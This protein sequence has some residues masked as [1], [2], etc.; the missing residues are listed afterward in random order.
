MPIR[1]QEQFLAP[2][3]ADVHFLSNRGANG[4]D[5][6]ISSGIGAAHASGRPTTIV[7]GELGFLHDIGA[8]AALRDVTT[9]VRI[10]VIDNGG[11]GIFHFL[12]QQTALDPAEFEALFG[13]PRAVSVE[14]AAALFDLPYRRLESLADLP[15][16]LAAGTG[17]IEVRTDRG[18]QR[19]RPPP[20]HRARPR[21]PQQLIGPAPR[22]APG[23]QTGACT[24][25]S[26]R[27][28]SFAG[29][30]TKVGQVPSAFDCITSPFRPRNSSIPPGVRR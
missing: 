13:T 3:P 17:L 15:T 30:A 7:T 9:P 11:G 18:D 20:R 23:I 28:P 1:D 6:L 21:R 29:S 10:L 2:G 14:R 26:A 12:P 19:R 5:G 4:I 22:S 25:A 8:L 24:D 16:A 27:L